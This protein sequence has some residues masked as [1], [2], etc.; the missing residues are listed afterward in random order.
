MRRVP[1]N[2]PHETL[3]HSRFIQK[4]PAARRQ[5]ERAQN[6]DNISIS[7]KGN[8]SKM[9]LESKFRRFPLKCTFSIV[10]ADPPVN[11]VGVAVQSKYFAVGAVVSWARAGVGAVATQARGLARYGTE[12]LDAL[13]K[14]E[15]PQAALEAALAS[16]P[17]AAHRQVGLVN[18]DGVAAHYTGDECL[19]WAG[20]RSGPGYSVQGNILAGE[21]VIESMAQAFVDTP[22]SLAERMLTSLEAGQ[23]AGGDKRGQQSSALLVEQL[24][25]ED[26]G[27]EGIDR[28]VDLRVDDHVAPIQ[29]LGRLFGLWQIEEANEQAML[30]Y[31]EDDYPA[32]MAILEKANRRFPEESRILYNLACFACLSGLVDESLKH[33]R[34]AVKLESSWR[35]F[36]KQDPD[37]EAVRD[38]SAF[39]EITSG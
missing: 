8:K 10:A 22:G 13:A 36:A 32:A 27:A 1:A 15:P 28:L 14:G 20:A 21:Q 5:D 37:F 16:D 30:R 29:E 19:A 6:L 31:D 3:Q 39:I 24:G 25:Y 34:E 35:E 18:A 11:Q 4:K 23:A 9:N 38:S 26:V 7:Q 33:L 2:D 12:L 17:L